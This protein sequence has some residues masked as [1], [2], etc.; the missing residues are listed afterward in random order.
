MSPPCHDLWELDRE[1]TEDVDNEPF[2]LDRVPVLRE[3]VEGGGG[4]VIVERERF[5]LP[6]IVLGLELGRSIEAQ[7]E[8]VP[9]RRRRDL[10][11]KEEVLHEVGVRGREDTPEV[12]LHPQVS[13]VRGPV[14]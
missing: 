11:R 12:S 4:G 5:L 2:V 3:A 6:Q 1:V 8:L 7:E 14:R 9:L 13:E 10:V